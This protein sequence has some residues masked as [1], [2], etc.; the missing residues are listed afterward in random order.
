[1]KTRIANFLR[2]LEEELGITFVF[3]EVDSA[4][5]VDGAYFKNGKFN[6]LEE[7]YE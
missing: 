5:R 6:K 2:A 3:I 1:M 7:L 4:K